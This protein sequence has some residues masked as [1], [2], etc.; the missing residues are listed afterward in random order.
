M[1]GKHVTNKDEASRCANSLQHFFA[2]SVFF[3]F[4]VDNFVS[5]LTSTQSI[6]YKYSVSFVSHISKHAQ[7]I[8]ETGRGVAG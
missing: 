3:A 6:G 2:A 8:I 1:P 5:E 4:S 7:A